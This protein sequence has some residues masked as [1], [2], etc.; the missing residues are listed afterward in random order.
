MNQDNKTG[1]GDSPT[2]DV[3][4]GL[5]VVGEK[6]FFT[7]TMQED[8]AKAKMDPAAFIKE[9]AAKKP[10]SEYI[11]PVSTPKEPSL[12]DKFRE[13]IEDL[14]GRDQP[15]PLPDTKTEGGDQPF[16]IRIPQKRSTISATTIILMIV[17]VL[18]VAGG[19]A[20]YWWFFM[21]TPATPVVVQVPEQKVTPQPQPKPVT[22][23]QP[24]PEPQPEPE[25]QPEPEPIATTTAP[26]IPPAPVATTTPPVITPPPAPIQAPEPTAPSAVVTLDHTATIE[27]TKL[28]KTI[29][30]EK[31]SSENAKITKEKATIRYVIKL[32]TPTEKKFLTGAEAAQLLGLLISADLSKLM[33]ASEL[34][35]YKSGASFRYGFVGAIQNSASVK[36]AALAWES[37]ILDDLTAL[38][39]EKPYQKP[40]TIVFSANTYFEFSKRYLN[41]PQPDMS[42]DWAVSSR[43]FVTATSKEMIYAVLDKARQPGK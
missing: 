34:I 29:L 30:L 28:D 5:P 8:V 42:L 39:V 26:V 6:K 14:A 25:L 27:L 9:V 12:S 36:S 11:P 16:Q 23:V 31:I 17:L 43:Y 24:E 7:H 40:A 37:T 15:F 10:F 32:T 2:N 20:A 13:P 4:G 18:L 41:M 3:P 1:L 38:Y 19:G 35:G 22:P 33:S 21:K